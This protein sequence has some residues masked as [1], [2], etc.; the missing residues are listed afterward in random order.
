MSRIRIAQS[1][2]VAVALLLAR[3]VFA[4]EVTAFAVPDGAGPHDVAPA[5]DGGVWFSAQRAGA[6]G[7]LDPT[8]AKVEMIPLGPGSAPHGVIVGPDGAPWVTDG[9]QN[10]IV[11]VDPVTHAI[12]RFP[13]PKSRDYANLNTAAFD[14]EGTLWF[15]GQNGIYGRLKANAEQVEVWPAPRG[16]GPYGINTTPSGEVYYVSLAG[17]YLAQMDKAAATVR[18]I[19]PSTRGAGTRRIWPDSTGNLWITEWDA[20]NLARFDPAK[21]AWA[22]WR[23]PG[24]HPMPYAVYV[25]QTDKVWLSDFGANAV[26]RFDPA[27]Q[28]FESFASPRRDANV[29]QLNGR[30][31]EVWGAESGTDHLMRFKFE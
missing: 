6:L 24:Q 22:T 27:T 20:G 15:T 28:K 8:T 25:D 23:P 19:E 12:T 5:S 30:K 4:V 13:L 9:G 14:R 18:V 31:G 16:V 26:L 11:R 29:R 2:A 21:Q 10:A 17:S 1:I 7:Q 3:P